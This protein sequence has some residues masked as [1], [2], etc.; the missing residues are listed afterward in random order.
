M[1]KPSVETKIEE[2]LQK[3][4]WSAEYE[5]DAED[6]DYEKAIESISALFSTQQAQMRGDYQKYIDEA[7]KMES[8]DQ[9][10]SLIK[11]VIS[12]VVEESQAQMREKIQMLANGYEDRED[13]SS[14]NLHGRLQAITDLLN[15][16]GEEKEGLR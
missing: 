10:D 13:L 16:L 14:D 11:A 8:K 6:N 3:L 15:I 9:A 12:Q 4:V 1:T 2:I 5:S 7:L